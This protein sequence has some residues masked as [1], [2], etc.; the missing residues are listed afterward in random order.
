MVGDNGESARPLAPWAQPTLCGNVAGCSAKGFDI[1]E[2]N[3]GKEFWSYQVFIRGV[4]LPTPFTLQVASWSHPTSKAKLSGCPALWCGGIKDGFK[5]TNAAIE[6]TASALILTAIIAAGISAASSGGLAVFFS[7][8]LG[9]TGLQTARN[10]LD[11]LQGMIDSTEDHNPIIDVITD[12]VKALLDLGGIVI[13]ILS[14]KG[15]IVAS[16]I[17]SVQGNA[18]ILL[19]ILAATGQILQGQKVAFKNALGAGMATTTGFVG[20][21]G[22]VAQFAGDALQLSG[23]WQAYQEYSDTHS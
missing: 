7:N 8:F 23:D 21:I 20:T 3:E 17:K 22:G 18:A 9:G 1:R 5:F 13:N 4:P 15:V 12:A 19:R 11:G 14:M 10:L 6:A 2:P 16:G